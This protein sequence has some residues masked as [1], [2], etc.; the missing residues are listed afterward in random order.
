MNYSINHTH[1]GYTI[2][3]YN[4]PG[5]N[6]NDLCRY[7]GENCA[8][9]MAFNRLLR[10]AKKR[11]ISIYEMALVED[12]EN[13]A[14]Y[15]TKSWDAYYHSESKSIMIN[16]LVPVSVK[17]DALLNVLCLRETF[18]RH[19]QL[20]Y[21]GILDNRREFNTIIIKFINKVIKLIGWEN[22]TKQ[23]AC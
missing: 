10:Y 18:N 15:E 7:K 20:Y 16:N 5:I 1:G 8:N 9:D 2:T 22:S 17:V 6:K 11:G 19:W 14:S 12:K 4:I 21:R 13:T 23:Y 3:V